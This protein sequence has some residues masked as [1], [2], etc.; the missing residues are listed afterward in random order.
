MKNP[1]KDVDQLT[2]CAIKEPLKDRLVS[3]ASRLLNSQHSKFEDLS[4]EDQNL[5]KQFDNSN[6]CSSSSLE[7][8]TLFLNSNTILLSTRSAPASRSLPRFT[9]RSSATS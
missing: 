7:M 5:W 9:K 3:I 6:I 1:L 4:E 8:K 2:I